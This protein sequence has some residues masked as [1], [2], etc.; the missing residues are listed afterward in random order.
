[1]GEL[2]VDMDK[3]KGGQPAEN[4]SYRGTGL[5]ELG[6]GKNQSHRFQRI[7]GIPELALFSWG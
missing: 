4:W 6:F 3:H 5:K 7:A 2:L 1:M